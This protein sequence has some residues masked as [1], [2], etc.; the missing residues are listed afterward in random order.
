[1]SE[2]E[3]PTYGSAAG[4][5]AGEGAPARAPDLRRA[6]DVLLGL[7]CLVLLVLMRLRA[8]DPLGVHNDSW[9][10]ANIVVS[11]RNVALNGSA[12]YGGVAQ[13]QV[14]RPPF[15][16][17][18]FYY[19]AH[20]PLGTYRLNWFVDALGGRSLAAWRWPPAVC[21]LLSLV[22][23][24][25]LLGRVAGRWTAL[26]ATAVMGSAYG[27]LAY[28]DDV[29]HGYAGVLVVGMMLSYVAGLA[30][31]GRRR[32]VLLAGSWLCVFANGFLSWEWLPWSQV[33]YWGHAVLFGAPFRRRWLLV[34]ALAPVLAF[35]IQQHQ[36]SAAIGGGG[37]GPGFVEDLLRR[38]VG[39]DEAVDTPPGVTLATYPAHVLGRFAE[40]Y[41]IELSTV[42]LLAI[43][44]GLLAGG[45]GADLRSAGPAF[46]WMALLFA[47][48]AS[49]W[50][51]MI[52]HTAVHHHV[53]RHALFFYALV[54]GACLAAAA[55]VAAGAPYSKW[56]RAAAA[57]IGLA[58]AVPHADGCYRD[59]RMHV[60][61]TYQDPRGWSSGWG[62]GDNLS[63]L[64]RKLPGDVLVLTN[65]N[66][67]PLM[68][69]WTNLPVYPATLAPY[70]HRRGAPIRP[71]ARLRI[72]LTASHL[73]EL[74][75][76]D[77][78]PMV[79]AYFFYAEPEAQYSADPTLWQLVDGTWTPP[80]DSSRFEN[81]REVVQGGGNSRYP[82]V[83]RGLNWVVFRADRLFEHLP[84]GGAGPAPPT[85]AEYGPPR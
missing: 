26:G 12:K 34:F 43:A 13:H 81:F 24:Y 31:A 74:Y 32:G 9:T 44:W 51:V 23:W 60:D 70:P 78:P 50:C 2:T 64:A 3:A 19:Y 47:C 57:G 8:G 65:H 62:E 39:L 79:F 29:H 71:D 4:A 14:D 73:K 58:V 76:K 59:F 11:A 16:N 22:L 84:E 30:A 49:W 41:G 66:R 37:G 35:A 80:Q 54:V 17:D 36:R 6:P 56:A 46:R 69:Y 5:A 72:E 15:R 83:A 33:F 48:A 21:S 82:L 85:L 61:R 42:W 20:Y 38:T 68:R 63:D 52:Q 53:M 10:T 27:F 45:V 75:G 28:A 67:L 18:P 40:F 77:L 7:L 25:L 1:M 55:R